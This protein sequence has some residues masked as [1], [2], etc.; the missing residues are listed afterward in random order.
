M[1]V[2]DFN[3]LDSF[4]IPD[5][6]LPRTAPLHP[7][8]WWHPGSVVAVVMPG[9]PLWV[10]LMCNGFHSPHFDQN[11]KDGPVRLKLIN[12]T[13]ARFLQV[14]VEVDAAAQHP[15]FRLAKTR[16]QDGSSILLGGAIVHDV[17][18]II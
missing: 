4:W 1:W 2:D 17:L 9:L 14:S 8:S 18:F 13:T 7:T 11:L 10:A 16:S 6:I 5:T 12:G 15:V 3:D